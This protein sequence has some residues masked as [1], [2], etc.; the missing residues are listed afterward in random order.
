MVN[1]ME[2]NRSKGIKSG[3][4][5][6]FIKDNKV[7]RIIF[8]GNLDLYW[9]LDTNKKYTTYEEAIKELYDTFTIT[10]ENYQIYSLFK[11][12]LDN[13]K[14]SNIFTP[15]CE[16]VLT[17]DDEVIELPPTHEELERT[18]RL[19]ES[20]KEHGA[21]QRIIDGEAI[22]WHSDEE[23]YEIADVLRMSEVDDCIVLEFLRPELTG[24]KMGIRRPSTICIRF[25][26]SGSYYDPFNIA[27][28]R[29]YNELQK[30]DPEY[31]KE[32]HQIHIEE[33]PHILKRGS[34]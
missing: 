21:Y 19:N 29:M 25:R 26:N 14:S 13:I 22:T 10:K 4:D 8:G 24:E 31:D 32:Y 3:Y 5:Y 2:I 18:K 34:V 17:E 30:F 6:E 27:F 12:L 1:N 23:P 28:M 15:I 20:L 9:S 16:P 33:L 7:L 11:D